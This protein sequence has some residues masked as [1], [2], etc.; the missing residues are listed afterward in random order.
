[1]D[2]IRNLNRY[3]KTILILM[4]AV[5]L[6]FAAVYFVTVQRAG[7]EYRDT[8]FVPGQENGSTVYSGKI[9]GQQ[10][11][12]TVSADK[13]VVF[14]CGD[15]IYGPYTAKE[16]PTAIP[17]D[18][19]T[20]GALTGVE[21]RQG[22][23]VLFRGGVRRNRDYYLLFNEDGTLDN[24]SLSY[25]S[26]DG[27]ERDENGNVVDPMEPSVSD[28]LELMDGPELTHKGVWFAWFGAALV[29]V[30][31]ALSIL[32]ADE[33]FRWNLAFRIRNAEQAEPSDL[34]VAGRYIS[35]TV[36]AVMA[37]IIFVVGLQ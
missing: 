12:F 21:L 37:L 16:D 35:W 4:T 22:E 33:L 19:E 23:E 2:R 5:A 6:V 11:R 24:I 36:L 31:N 1:M 26:G 17:Q 25:V 30:L 27:V 28:I 8:I 34:E 32:F 9:R 13:T 15:R 3:Q 29:C 18:A 20:A 14:Q 7:Y 10:A